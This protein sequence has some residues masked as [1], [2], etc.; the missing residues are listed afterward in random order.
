MMATIEILKDQA[1]SAGPQFEL[2][3]VLSGYYYQ[4]HI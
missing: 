2:F 4:L 3:V 1:N